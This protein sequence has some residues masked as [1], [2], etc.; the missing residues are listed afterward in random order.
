MCTH[1]RTALKH[2]NVGFFFSS[3]TNDTQHVLVVQGSMKVMEKNNNNQTSLFYL[4][5]KTLF[6]ELTYLRFSVSCTKRVLSWEVLSSLSFYNDWIKH[7][8]LLS[9]KRQ[10]VSFGGHAELRT[11]MMTLVFLNPGTILI[12]SPL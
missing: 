8:V 1:H 6:R 5:Y 7:W 2:H 9:R 11:F 10:T 12:A 4:W 3:F